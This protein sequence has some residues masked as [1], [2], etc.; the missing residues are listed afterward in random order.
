LLDQLA[1]DFDCRP[2]LHAGAQ[3]NGDQF[4][5]AGRIHAQFGQAF[6]RPLIFWEVLDEIARRHGHGGFNRE[7][8]DGQ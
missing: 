1:G 3:K 8:E 5:V 4:S 7:R 6:A 2:A